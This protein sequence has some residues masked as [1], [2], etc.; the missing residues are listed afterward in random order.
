MREFKRRE[1]QRAKMSLIRGADGQ[2]RAGGSDDDIGDIWAEQQRIRLREAIE[3][4]KVKAQK[5]K[6]GWR[7]FYAKQA[8]KKL[9]DKG[10]LIPREPA[11][12]PAETKLVEIKISLPST[13]SLPKVALPKSAIPAKV[14]AIPKPG[15]KVL[16]MGAGASLVVCALVAYGWY[17]WYAGHSAARKVVGKPS[18]STNHST[19]GTSTEQPHYATLL[20]QGKSIESL[21]G[22]HRVSPDGKDPVFAFTD[23]IDGI[24]ISVSEQP[25]PANFQDDTDG[26]VAKLAQNFGANEKVMAGHTAVYIG[27]S[28]KGPQSIITS[29]ADLLILIKSQ[30][31]I[32]NIHWA[33]YISNLQ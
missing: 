7:K 23:S 29:Q 6:L 26:Q 21:G 13:I 18:A 24:G 14:K 25:L 17:H 4:D 30:H 8:K 16:V 19:L 27:T 32:S 31:K 22:W 2:L 33:N 12:K 28:I 9:E 11:P 20:P 15:K 1:P 5:K 3:A 10:V